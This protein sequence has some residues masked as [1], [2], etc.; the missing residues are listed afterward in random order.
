MRK[1]KIVLKNV[2]ELEIDSDKDKLSHWTKSQLKAL[3]KKAFMQQAHST[4][5]NDGKIKIK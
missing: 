3:A 2:V 1:V 5:V 4:F